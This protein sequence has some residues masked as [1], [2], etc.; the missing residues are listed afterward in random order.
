[1]KQLNDMQAEL[2]RL[3]DIFN[4]H[5]YNGK[6]NKPVIAVQ[7][8]GRERRT[9]GW[10]T[11]NKVWK[12]H[13]SGEYYYEITVCAE[14]LYR[15]AFEIC[16]TLLHEMVHLYCIEND[17]K[18]TSR[19]AT[20]HNKRF[21][22]IAE[23]HGLIISY[24][25]TIGWSVTELSEEAKAFIAENAN[26][27][28]FILT[29]GRHAPPKPPTKPVDEPSDEGEG[30]SGLQGGT[31][32]GNSPD[33]PKQSMRKYICPK[34]GCIISATKDVNVICGECQVAFV[35]KGEDF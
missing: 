6:I 29:R 2:G 20:Y 15:T 24:H 9:T 34:C 18:D 11:L 28:V 4:E 21:K 5:Y 23:A 14:Y 26:Q 22:E 19:S 17:I 7:T 8:S 32:G 33:K 3:F 12:D 31:E 16:A 30:E 10:C 1:M 25:K 27:N 13:S 35:K